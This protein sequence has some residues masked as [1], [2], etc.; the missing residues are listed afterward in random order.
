MPAMVILSVRDYN[1]SPEEAA[2]LGLDLV[3]DEDDDGYLENPDHD[4]GMVL[5][6]VLF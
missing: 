4:E 6:R 2:A 5:V 1:P 3:A